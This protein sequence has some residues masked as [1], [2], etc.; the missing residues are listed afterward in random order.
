MAAGKKSHVIPLIKRGSLSDMGKSL[1]EALKDSM[2]KEPKPKHKHRRSMDRINMLG[3]EKEKDELIAP[4]PVAPRPVAPRHVVEHVNQNDPKPVNP[5]KFVK[6]QY[7]DQEIAQKLKGYIQIP[8]SDFSKI[9]IGEFV[10]FNKGQ[11]FYA[12]GQIVYL[13]FNKDKN[14]PYWIY[15]SSLIPVD[16]KFASRYTVYWKDITRLWKRTNKPLEIEYIN[17]KLEML[18]AKVDD[19]QKKIQALVLFLYSK[20]G[21]EFKEHLK[22]LNE[23]Q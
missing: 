3:P 5:P 1:S 11:S 22:R 6:K 14:T 19:I 13:G 17:T 16:G 8:G 10:R 21:S 12:G 23:S 9:D 7:T 4:R 2:E 15:T 18:N 20:H